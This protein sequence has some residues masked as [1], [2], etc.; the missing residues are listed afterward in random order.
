MLKHEV[1]F[2]LLS[3]HD[4]LKEPGTPFRGK[5]WIHTEGEDNSNMIELCS[6][7]KLGHL[8]FEECT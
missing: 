1:L 2:L 7:D 3:K 6:L 8:F 5:K 4:I